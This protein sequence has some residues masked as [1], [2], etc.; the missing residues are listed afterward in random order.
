MN[1]DISECGFVEE[2]T[3]IWYLTVIGK[4]NDHFTAQSNVITL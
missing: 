3:K 4:T 1:P 2:Y